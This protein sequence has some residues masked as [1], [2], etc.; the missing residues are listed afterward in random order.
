M[1]K[2]RVSGPVPPSPDPPARGVTRIKLLLRLLLYG[3]LTVSRPGLAVLV[4]Y[5]AVAVL[6]YYI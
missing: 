6:L 1:I 3:P 4:G 5:N 2:Y